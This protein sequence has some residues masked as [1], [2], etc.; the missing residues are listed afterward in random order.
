[1]SRILEG[2]MKNRLTTYLDKHNYRQNNAYHS[3]IKPH[4]QYSVYS[5]TSKQNINTLQR[6]QN[7][8]LKI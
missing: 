7:K 5:K 4:L 2:L 6:L 3:I 8:T 1:M